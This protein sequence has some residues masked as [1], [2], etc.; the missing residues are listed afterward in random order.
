MNRRAHTREPPEQ[1]YMIEH[2]RAK[3]AGCI[4]IVQGNRSDDLGKVA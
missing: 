3:T 1:L 4:F 2:S